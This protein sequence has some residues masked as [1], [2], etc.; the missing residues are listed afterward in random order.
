MNQPSQ[1]DHVDAPSEHSIEALLLEFVSQ[2][3]LGGEEIAPDDGLLSEGMVD[4]MGM[5]RLATFLHEKFDVQV[6]V[7]D[8]VISNFRTI[9]VLQQ[10][11]SRRL[12]DADRHGAKE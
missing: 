2:E 5:V 11:L 8:F 9:R 3:L 7:Q 10:Y 1:T 6:P 4:S 12:N